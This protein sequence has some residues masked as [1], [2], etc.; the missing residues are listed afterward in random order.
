MA[1]VVNTIG[2]PD[3]LPAGGVLVG[4]YDPDEKPGERRL[5]TARVRTAC[6]GITAAAIR[7]GLGVTLQIGNPDLA[8]TTVAVTT[9]PR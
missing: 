8:E 1:L 6:A 2:N 5:V 4:F 9:T 3:I 7:A